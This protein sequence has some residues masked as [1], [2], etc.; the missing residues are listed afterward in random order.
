MGGSHGTSGLEL[1]HFCPDIQLNI[2]PRIYSASLN[3][4]QTY[5]L[6]TDK[7]KLLLSITDRQVII[8]NKPH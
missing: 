8:L 3:K 5:L 1:D 4:I 2:F 6:Q 7:C